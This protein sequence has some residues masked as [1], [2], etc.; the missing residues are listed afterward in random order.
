MHSL[1][2]F[3]NLWRWITTY[4][5]ERHYVNYVNT[6]LKKRNKERKKPQVSKNKMDIEVDPRL[7]GQYTN[8]KYAAAFESLYEAF[9]SGVYIAKH[10]AAIE[11][12]YTFY[13]YSQVG[14][15]FEGRN[16]RDVYDKELQRTFIKLQILRT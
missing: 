4:L 14:I 9:D 7:W 16:R 6:N 13:F 10:F 15:K 8:F 12:L 2:F 1:G 11:K 5:T 3:K